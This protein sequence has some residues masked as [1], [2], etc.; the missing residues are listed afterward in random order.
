[1]AVGVELCRQAGPVGAAGY[2][3]AQRLG[4]A[5]VSVVG[6]VGSEVGGG[7]DLAGQVVPGVGVALDGVVIEVAAG[8]A[9]LSL[10]AD[11]GDDSV[12]GV[13]DSLS[14]GDFDGAGERPAEDL[15]PLGVVF[16]FGDRAVGR[17]DLHRPARVVVEG[18][19]G[20]V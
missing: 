5:D 20:G 17:V 16:V 7:Q 19:R 13:G 11:G 9:G 12:V 2:G 8:A 1:L 18:E 6:V 10:E 15:P 3:R 4:T 14:L